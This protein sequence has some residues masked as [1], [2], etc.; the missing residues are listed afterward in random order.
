MVCLY[1][2]TG[3]KGKL[4][5]ERDEQFLPGDR[6]AALKAIPSLPRP[7][8]AYKILAAGRLNPREAF[9][10]VFSRIKSSD[11]VAV[12]MF[13]PDGKSGDIVAENTAYVNEFGGK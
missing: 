5:V 1:N 13:P 3:Y 11:G 2:I 9:K 8:F 4:G 12:G 6:E 7:C 10:E